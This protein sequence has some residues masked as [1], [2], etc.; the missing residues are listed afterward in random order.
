MPRP[1]ESGTSVGGLYRKTGVAAF[2]AHAPI[3]SRPCR[4][5]QCP[6]KIYSE[7][8]ISEGRRPR[9]PKEADTKPRRLIA[10]LMLDETML[11]DAWR[12]PVKP[13]PKTA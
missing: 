5:F 1:T 9:Q 13:G 7:I 2:E 10:E 11:Q 12:K 8:E 3:D 6:K 4:G